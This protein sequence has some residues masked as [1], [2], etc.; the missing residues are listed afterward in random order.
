MSSHVL[1]A[2]FS[3]SVVSS[4]LWPHGLQSARL[5]RL[6]NSPGKNTGVGSH[7]LLQGIFPTQGSN[8]GLLHYRWILYCLS[9]QGSPEK[10]LNIIDFVWWLNYYYFL[11]L[12]CFPFF[13][14]F[15]TSL[16]KCII[17]TLGKAWEAKVFSRQEAGRGHGRDLTWEGPIRPC[18]WLHFQCNLSKT[19]ITLSKSECSLPNHPVFPI[20]LVYS[21]LFLLPECD[22][23]KVL[24]CF[25]DHLYFFFLSVCFGLSFTVKAF[26]KC[27]MIFVYPFLFK[28][29]IPF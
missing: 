4:P 15:L 22:I 11:F 20:I 5:F 12:D 24:L 6:W 27:L 16:I 8:P 7:S 13:L 14:N 18:S 2:H 26:L 19:E 25:L 23:L 3:L 28:V 10:E 21:I 9:H 29:G 1:I 17:W